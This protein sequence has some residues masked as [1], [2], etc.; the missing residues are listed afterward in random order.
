MRRI[1]GVRLLLWS[2]H[3]VEL[4]YHHAVVQNVSC[5]IYMRLPLANL[6][7]PDELDNRIVCQCTLVCL[8]AR[9]PS[10]NAFRQ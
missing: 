6:R 5:A 1:Y 7:S 8:F 9:M 3:A 2:S 10:F 4:L